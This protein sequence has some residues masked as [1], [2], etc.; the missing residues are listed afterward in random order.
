MWRP[1]PSRF[2]AG[3]LLL[4]HCA[5]TLP[6]F[7]SAWV[8]LFFAASLVLAFCAAALAADS[9]SS[10]AGKKVNINQA[11][12]EQLANLPRVG[13]KAAQRVVEYRKA[14]GPFAR[15]EDLMEVKGFGEK[16]F[17]QLK[18]YLVVS[19][20]TTLDTKVSSA[21]SFAGVPRF[22]STAAK[23]RAAGTCMA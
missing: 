15:P 2:G 14:K 5:R 11:S 19:G 12:A 3:L 6:S 17:E 23:T 9:A 10:A 8:L 18:P 21:G 22:V 20:P 7:L 1:G 4:L 16:H 13:A